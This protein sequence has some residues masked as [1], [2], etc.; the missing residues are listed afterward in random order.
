MSTACNELVSA[1]ASDTPD[2]VTTPAINKEPLSPGSR[3][4]ETAAKPVVNPFENLSKV[5]K[6]LELLP[7]AELQQQ[8]RERQHNQQQQEAP[9]TVEDKDQGLQRMELKKVVPLLASIF[10]QIFVK[11]R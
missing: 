3:A 7:D 6:T 5:Q 9:P 10:D 1:P 8:D 4:A 2:A 11:P